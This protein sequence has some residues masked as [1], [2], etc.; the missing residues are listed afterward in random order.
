MTALFSTP[1]NPAPFV[2]TFEQGVSISV[3]IAGRVQSYPVRDSYYATAE[4]ADYLCAKFG[5]LAVVSEPA[6]GPGPYWCSASQRF[7]LWPDGVK[8][9][10]GILADYYRRNPE[11]DFPGLADKYVNGLLKSAHDAVGS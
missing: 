10:A 8:F 7:L 5:A 4:T 6:F 2:P 11:A 1:P 9:N 3:D